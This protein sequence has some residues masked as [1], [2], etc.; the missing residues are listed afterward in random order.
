MSGKA[1]AS[2]AP[3]ERERAVDPDV[4]MYLLRHDT[5]KRILRL[6]INGE[7]RTSPKEAAVELGE[8]LTDVAYHF[9]VLAEYE[10]VELVGTAMVRGGEQHFY[11]TNPRFVDDPLVRQILAATESD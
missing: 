5:R 4:A 1:D 11:F 8:P 6:L 2:E 7:V 3:A 10:A 9:R